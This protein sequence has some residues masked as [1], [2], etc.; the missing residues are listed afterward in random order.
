MKGG[1]P[2]ATLAG[3]GAPHDG[4]IPTISSMNAA[5]RRVPEPA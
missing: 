4:T 2:A 5:I 3:R 1:E